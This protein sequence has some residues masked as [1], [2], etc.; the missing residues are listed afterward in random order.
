MF[1]FP[2]LS[3]LFHSIFGLPGYLPPLSN[4]MR[5]FFI[6]SMYVLFFFVF[7]CYF[8]IDYSCSFR[9]HVVWCVG[10]QFVN[11]R[12]S[13]RH[14]VKFKY[15]QSRLAVAAVTVSG[16]GAEFRMVFGC[17]PEGYNAAE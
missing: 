9:T 13:N 8:F 3:V 15:K 14:D 17:L 10:W 16:R 4:P 5:F 12:L 2:L 6:I 7:V 11:C 1:R